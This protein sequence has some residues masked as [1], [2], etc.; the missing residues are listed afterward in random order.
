MIDEQLAV[1]Y[2]VGRAHTLL[3]PKTY[4]YQEIEKRADLT[5]EDYGEETLR[6]LRETIES[7][8]AEKQEHMDQKYAYLCILQEDLQTVIDFLVENPG[9]FDDRQ[10]ELREYARDVAVP[11]IKEYLGLDYEPPAIH[12]VDRM[13]GAI[14]PGRRG[15]GL[16]VDRWQSEQYG[17]PEG[18]FVHEASL[19]KDSEILLIHELTHPAV[20]AFPNFVP[21]FDEGLCNLMAFWIY[22]ESSGDL[23]FRRYMRLREEFGDFYFSPGRLFRRPNKLFCSLLMIG[24]FELVKL[25]A[26]YKRS[27]PEK[28]DWDRL[29][30]LLMDGVDLDTL[31]KE[32]VREPVSLPEPEIT[33]LQRR[34]V[35]TVLAH[36]I[37]HVLTPLGMILWRRILERQPTPGK[38]TLDELKH[39]K[40]TPEALDQ[41]ISELRARGPL[42]WL[43]EDGHIEPYTGPYTGTAHF[44]YAGLVRVWAKKYERGDW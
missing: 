18:I 42:I 25:L 28:V 30:T 21:W 5:L 24:G 6:K 44:L 1:R 23:R 7:V 31:L 10:D 32:A 40:I 38:W 29:P 3:Y 27:T 9:D 2:A 13:P 15:G 35:A 41:T 11:K 8:E 22:G 26:E 34:I 43:F 39:E 17:I 37:S 12:F 4:T 36:N 19:M 33:P 14:N 16:G 20:E